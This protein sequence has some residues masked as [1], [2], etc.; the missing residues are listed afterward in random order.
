MLK[1]SQ[2][3]HAPRV[4]DERFDRIS[5]VEDSLFNRFKRTLVTTGLSKRKIAPNQKEGPE[6]P[7][8]G[9]VKERVFVAVCE[10]GPTQQDPEVPGA[11]VPWRK[12]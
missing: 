6:K 1:A 4:G 5:R 8:E 9:L 2:G 10:G 3:A 11:G 7:D 12:A